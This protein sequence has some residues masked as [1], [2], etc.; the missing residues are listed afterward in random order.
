MGFDLYPRHKKAGNFHAGA[1]SWHWML[2]AGVGLAVGYGEGYSPAHFVY[3][4]RADGLCIGYNDGARVTAKEAK[5]MAQLARWVHRHQKALAEC[6]DREPEV[7][8]NEMLQNHTGLYKLPV[9]EEFV[10]KLLSFADWAEKSGGFTV[11]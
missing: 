7:R 4:K 6:F 11:H 1:F 5:Q 2:N 9:R 10:S 8:K 3:E